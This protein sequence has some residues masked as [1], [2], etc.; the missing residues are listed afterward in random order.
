MAGSREIKQL[1]ENLK[2]KAQPRKFLSYAD[3]V[4]RAPLFSSLQLKNSSENVVND[5]TVSVSS[6]ENILIESAKTFEEVPY[7]G[8][9]EVTF[10]GVLSPVWF[11]ECNEVRPVAFTVKVSKDKSV[12]AAE[13]V[14]STALPFDWWSGLQGNGEELAYFVRPRL[15]DCDKILAEAAE[16]LKRWKTDSDIAGYAAADKN[17]VRWIAAAIFMAIKRIAITESEKIDLQAPMSAGMSGLIKEKRANALQ[18]AVFAAAC[19]ERAKL[20]PVLIIGKEHVACGVWLYD[21]CSLDGVS[22]DMQLIDK[23]ITPGINNLSV[24]DVDDLFDNKSVNYTTAETHFA[25]KLRA[26]YYEIYVDVRRS[27]LDNFHPLPL[28]T[29]GVKGYEL[30][31]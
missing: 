21:T 30:L 18:V 7:S 24:F 22:D 5:I 20:H 27:R 31:G 9:I 26:D 15:A 16:Q 13:R 3:V 6:E 11:M 4:Y 12:I 10:D 25:Q 23:Y 14:E 17:R 8:P 28:R 29:Q 19:L 2:L 1:Q